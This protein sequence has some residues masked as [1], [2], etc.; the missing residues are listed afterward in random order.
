MNVNANMKTIDVIVAV[1][2]VVGGLNWGLV[3]VANFNLVEY[4][5]GTTLI[6]RIVYVVVGL[7]ALWQVFGWKQIQ[8]RWVHP[9]M[10]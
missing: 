9:T 8:H 1:L 7:C 3:G 4:L 10:A 2:V 5:F 6:A